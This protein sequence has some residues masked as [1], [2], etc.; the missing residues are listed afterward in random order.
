MKTIAV[1][2]KAVSDRFVDAAR[3]DLEQMVK[4]ASRVERTILET[5]IVLTLIPSIWVYYVFVKPVANF[6]NDAGKI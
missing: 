1:V 3:S 6:V 4:V 5:T 2:A